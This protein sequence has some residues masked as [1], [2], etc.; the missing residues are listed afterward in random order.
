MCQNLRL[1]VGTTRKNKHA[2]IYHGSGIST[3]LCL[4]MT[5]RYLGGGQFLDIIDMHGVGK[6]TF[7]KLLWA[8]T[9]GINK[10]I[11]M[12]GIPIKTQS[13]LAELSAGFERLKSGALVGCVGSIDG[14]TLEI[15]KPTPWDTLFPRQ[16]MNKKGFFSINCQEICDT[17]LKFTWCSLKSLGM[18]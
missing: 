16:F 2:R 12:D 8:T 5:L 18:V 3:E 13:A 7:Y 17:N 14:I 6:S 15:C 10:V 1:Y 11:K 9:E 4:S